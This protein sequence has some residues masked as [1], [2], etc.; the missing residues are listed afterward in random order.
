MLFTAPLI[1]YDVASDGRFLGVRRDAHA[2]QAPVNVV[3]NWMDELKRLAPG[4]IFRVSERP[5]ERQ[6]PQLIRPAQGV[7]RATRA[8]GLIAVTLN[9]IV[10]AVAEEVVHEPGAGVQTP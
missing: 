7:E 2:S 10:D 9:R 5:Q 1:G 4:S 6:H 3:M 8:V